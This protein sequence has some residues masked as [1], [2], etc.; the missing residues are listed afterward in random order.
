MELQKF[1]EAKLSE[2]SRRTSDINLR[3]SV[4]VLSCANTIAKDNDSFLQLRNHDRV[5][6]YYQRNPP[7]LIPLLFVFFFPLLNSVAQEFHRNI[8]LQIRCGIDHCDPLD[9][10]FSSP[11]LWCFKIIP[12]FFL[13]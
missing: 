12:N 1:Y 2:I 5:L 3:S 8:A 7:T 9:Y 4:S 6:Y 13:D 11:Q 10:Y